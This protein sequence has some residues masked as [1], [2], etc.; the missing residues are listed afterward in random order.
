M[1]LAFGLILGTSSCKVYQDIPSD[2]SN[3]VPSI[4]DL[5]NF[6]EDISVGFNQ[7]YL[8]DKYTR[9][10][11]GTGML[12]YSY[13]NEKDPFNRHTIYTYILEVEASAS[14]AEATLAKNVEAF[15]NA[16]NHEGVTERELR[17]YDLPGELHFVAEYSFEN[18][19]FATLLVAQI[20]N[21][22]VTFF[23]NSGD[24]EFPGLVDR[25][26]LPYLEYTANKAYR[27]FDRIAPMQEI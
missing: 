4:S 20:N 5:D 6:Y 11:D 7:D 15:A 12:E 17:K 3:H 8:E 25:F 9:F 22:V 16:L 24:D 19:V 1:G 18:K 14:E 13:D 21:H 26:L 10:Y 23:I 27:G 2:M